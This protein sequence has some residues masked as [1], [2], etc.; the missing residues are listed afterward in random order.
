MLRAPTEHAASNMEDLDI[1]DPAIRTNPEFDFDNEHLYKDIELIES[2]AKETEVPV[3]NTSDVLMDDIISHVP[4]VAYSLDRI[5]EQR[6]SDLSNPPT[7]EFY[8]GPDVEDEP[9]LIL[10]TSDNVIA[11]KPLEPPT[12]IICIDLGSANACIANPG[13]SS[14]TL[15]KD[16]TNISSTSIKIAEE[17]R[18]TVEER[19]GCS[20]SKTGCLKLYCEC[21]AGNKR[22]GLHCKCQGCKNTLGNE[23]EIE[24]ALSQITAKSDC[25]YYKRQAN[26]KGIV[27][28]NCDKSGCQKKYCFCYRDGLAINYY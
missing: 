26:N 14:D 1:F 22:C 28:C 17:D 21:L 15:N 9:P 19:K 27:S 3:V 7:E 12:P 24:V 20:C 4:P 25:S 16:N 5:I 8:M 6:Y 13:Q 23:K 11:R 10:P 18:T 2:V